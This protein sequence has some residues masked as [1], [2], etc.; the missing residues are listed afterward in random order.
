MDQVEK[1]KHHGHLSCSFC[2]KGQREVR[3][4]IAGPEGIYICDECTALCRDIM[5]EEIA[6]EDELAAKPPL[7]SSDDPQAMAALLVKACKADRRVPQ[8]ISDLAVALAVA[9]ER[10]LNPPKG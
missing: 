1:G 2:G 7:P 3:K 4:L 8:I 9:L 6:G 5:A 10:H